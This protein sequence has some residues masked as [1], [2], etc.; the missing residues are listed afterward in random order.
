MGMK[1]SITISILESALISIG[2]FLPK[3]EVKPPLGGYLDNRN[4]RFFGL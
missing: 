3:L 2:P 1:Y 4:H